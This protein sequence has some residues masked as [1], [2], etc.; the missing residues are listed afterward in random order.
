MI[1]ICTAWDNMWIKKKNNPQ[2][3]FKLTT[4]T[5]SVLKCFTWSLLKRPKICVVIEVYNRQDLKSLDIR[6]SRPSF[7]NLFK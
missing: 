4:P 7:G 3:V 5:L 1:I 6:S 2:E